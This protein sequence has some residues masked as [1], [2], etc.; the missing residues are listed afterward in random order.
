MGLM[1]EDLEHLRRDLEHIHSDVSRVLRL[2]DNTDKDCEARIGELKR[3]FKD[4]DTHV[5]DA[6]SHILHVE[7]HDEEGDQI[8]ISREK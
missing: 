8:E 4:L 5:H 6:L 7:G 1:S 2:L 3:H